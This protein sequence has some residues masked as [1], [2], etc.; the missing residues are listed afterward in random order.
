MAMISILNKVIVI[1]VILDNILISVTKTTVRV[2]LG[3]AGITLTKKIKIT[4]KSG[5]FVQNF[6]NQN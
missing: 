5:R 3:L 2:I 1:A 6:N 4:L